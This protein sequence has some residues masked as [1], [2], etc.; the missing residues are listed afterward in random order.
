MILSVILAVGA[1]P[2]PVKASVVKVENY[3]NIPAPELNIQLDNLLSGNQP[4]VI[5][6]VVTESE[7]N[8]KVAEEAK[9]KKEAQRANLTNNLAQSGTRYGN[10]EIIGQDTQ[11]LNCV[12][13]SK[14]RSGI[15]RTLGNGARAAIQGK[16]P[17]VGAIGSTVGTPHA[18]YVVAV[19]GNMITVEESNYQRGYLTRRVLPLSQF[20]GFVYN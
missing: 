20:I 11:F 16:D 18:V 3:V 10:Y 9:K 12:S 2:V 6:I 17:R 19:N 15:Y 8:K 13:Y 4:R 1:I 7:Y 5:E 14:Y